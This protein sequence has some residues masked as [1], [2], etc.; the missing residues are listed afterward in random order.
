MDTDI[1]FTAFQQVAGKSAD[2]SFFDE[3]QHLPGWSKV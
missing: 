1:L 2:L 3:I